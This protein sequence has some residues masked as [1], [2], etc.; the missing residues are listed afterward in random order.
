MSFYSGPVPYEPAGKKANPAWTLIGWNPIQSGDVAEN[1]SKILD[2]KVTN[3]SIYI[4][5]IPMHWPLDNVPGECYFESFVKLNENTVQVHGRIVNQRPDKTQY[6]AR[7][8]EL[9]AVYTNAP[10]HRL[11]TY[12]GKKPFT[13]DTLSTIHNHNFPETKSI[14]WASWQATE[15]WAAL[16][17]SNDYGLGVWNPDIQNFK[18]GYFGDASFKGGSKDMGTGYISPVSAEVLDHNITFDYNYTLIVGKLDEIRNYVYEHRPSRQLPSYN[19]K[20]DRQ[21][22]TFE[23]TTDAGWPIQ[24]ELDIRLNREAA[25]V[26]PVTLWNASDAGTLT[27]TAS[28]SHG[29]EKVRVYWRNIGNEFEQSNSLEFDIIS[30]GKMR[31]YSVPL[32]SSRHYRGLLNG[33][34]FQLDSTG[35]SEDGDVVRVQSITL[36]P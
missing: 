35:V 28:F 7:E 14:N 9:P 8:Q 11:I 21:H 32:S 22:W 33:L 17:N 31:T 23:N 15:S 16:V 24:N 3:D 2:S 29:G 13:S 5:C 1:S 19:F 18:G 26:G 25:L 20:K 27:L 30:D 10:Y 36:N 4:K 34:K 6:P 12:R